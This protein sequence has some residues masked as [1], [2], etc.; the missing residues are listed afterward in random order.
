MVVYSMIWEAVC[1]SSCAGERGGWL[2]QA[3]NPED[4]AESNKKKRKEMV[5]KTKTG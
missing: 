2:A 4:R 1:G 3:S 5:S